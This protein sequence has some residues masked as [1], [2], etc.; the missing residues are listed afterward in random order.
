NIAGISQLPWRTVGIGPLEPRALERFAGIGR[1]EA[2]GPD[3]RV[4]VFSPLKEVFDPIVLIIPDI[5]VEPVKVDQILDSNPKIPVL[6]YR[7]FKVHLD[8]GY[9]RGP[10]HKGASP[11]QPS[12][13]DAGKG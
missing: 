6:K 4:G 7:I 10:L 11:P 5:L 8:S 3:L 1:I 2:I 12:V 13:R 9:A